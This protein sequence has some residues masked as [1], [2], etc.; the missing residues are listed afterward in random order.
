VLVSRLRESDSVR[1]QLRSAFRDAT[2]HPTDDL[3][4]QEDDDIRVFS[5]AEF[6]PPEYVAITGAVRRPGRFAYHE[7]MTLRDLVLLAGGLADWAYLREAEVARRPLSAGG[8][9][10]GQATTGRL[11]VS[12][13][14]PLDSSY[15]LAR[16]NGDT[17]PVRQAGQTDGDG[18][19]SSRSAEFTLEPYDNVLILARPDWVREAG[20]P[21]G[22]MRA[23]HVVIDGEV[24]FPGTYTLLTADERLS[25]VLRRAGGLTP[26]AHPDGIVFYRRRNRVGRIDVDLAHVLADSTYRGNLLIEDGDS[27]HV[28]RFSAVVEVQGAVNAPRAVAYVPGEDLEYY[29]RAA[30]GPTQTAAT[31]HAYVTQPDGRVESIVTH[32]LWFA[33]RPTPLPGSTVYVPNGEKQPPTDPFSRLAAVGQL[34]AG[35][36]ALVAVIRH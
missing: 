31:G 10:E 3:A 35:V 29:I 24:R 34:V 26:E 9:A 13:R 18:H 2:G 22:A 11:A 32:R 23:A 27:I 16:R 14:V 28:P 7:G 6:R 30:G 33:R 1:V 19:T 12:Q 5:M 20:R 36:V 15:V 8:V 21:G 17:G 25:D 4:L